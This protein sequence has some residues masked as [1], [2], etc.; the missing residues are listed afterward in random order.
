MTLPVVARANGVNGTFWR[1]DVTFFNPS[2]AR[3]FLSVRYSDTTKSLSLGARE[4][5]LLAD[6]LTQFGYGGGNNPLFISWSGNSAPVVSSRTYT[7]DERGGTYGQSIDPVDAFWT[8]ARLEFEGKPLKSL[9]QGDVDF[10]LVPLVDKEAAAESSEA[11]KGV[12]DAVKGV[13]GDQV[14]DVRASQRLTSSASCLVASGEARDRALE[15]LL[16]QHDKGAAQSGGMQDVFMNILTTNGLVGR[17]VTDWAGPNAVLKRVAIKLGAPNLPGDTMKMT[18]T[19]KKKD[20]AAAIM[21]ANRDRLR[22]ILM[23]TLALVAGML[24]LALGTGPGADER[25]AIAVVVIGGQTLSLLLTLI[26]TPVVIPLSVIQTAIETAIP[27]TMTGKPDIPAPPGASGA[28][29]TWTVTREPFSVTGGPNGLTLSASLIG[30]LTA[31]VGHSKISS[32]T[33]R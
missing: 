14:S 4:T 33:A 9:S 22:P 24:P 31:T 29:I 6:V 2:N 12:L 7:T 28:E 16:A 25:R 18:G 32:S 20:D 21:Q 15:R 27:P 11:D 17:Y 19:V 3:V 5:Y 10:S 23:T 30:A 8:S 26:V 13:L 1:S